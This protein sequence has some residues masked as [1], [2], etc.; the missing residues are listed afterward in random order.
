MTQHPYEIKEEYVNPLCELI[1]M[2]NIVPIYPFILRELREEDLILENKTCWFYAKNIRWAGQE[3][4]W[5]LL[6]DHNGFY[7]SKGDMEFQLLFPWDSVAE[8]KTRIADDKSE[9]TIGLFQADGQHLTLT[10]S[11][12]VSLLVVYWLYKKI[13]VEINEAFKD[14]PIINW[15]SV[16]NDLGIQL[17]SFDSYKELYDVIP[18][19]LMNKNY[20]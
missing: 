6:I 8:I 9:M 20:V 19:Q 10:Q 4:Y 11:G 13:M 12:S 1:K 3:Q 16:E 18:K 15:T 17:K 14:Q 5:N 2:N 7:S